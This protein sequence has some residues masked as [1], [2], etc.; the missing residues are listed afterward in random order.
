MEVVE[1]VNDMQSRAIQL[2]SQ[3]KLIGLVPTMGALHEGLLSLV[4]LAREKMDV[5]V[6]SIF[7]NPIQFGPNEDFEQFPRQREGDLEACRA[8]GVDIVFLPTREEVY[9]E[10]FSTYIDEQWVAKDLC[11]I[12]RSQ[13]FKGV[14]T[15]HAKLFNLVRPDWAVFSQ[16]EAQKL[17]VVRKMVADLH[18]PVDIGVGTTVRDA[19]GVALDPRLQYLTDGQRQD[20]G[21]IYRALCEGKRLFD[22]GIRVVDRIVAETTH[23][24]TQSRRLRVIY[25]KIVDR[26]TMQPVRDPQSGK[27]LLMV[28]VWVDQ[29]R[30]IDNLEL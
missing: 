15:W 10:R 24:L 30:L 27:S 17:A 1:S 2:R 21:L 12:S 8:R 25:V 29:V 16:V 6:V 14:A 19:N 26:D 22:Q 3:G 28:A 9:P 5:V 11:G 4:D 23:Y 7:V 20:A 13:H 18:M